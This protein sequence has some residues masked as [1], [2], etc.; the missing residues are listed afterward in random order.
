MVERCGKAIQISK[1]INKKQPLVDSC[2][3][4]IKKSKIN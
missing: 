3:Q 4:A 1:I 2:R